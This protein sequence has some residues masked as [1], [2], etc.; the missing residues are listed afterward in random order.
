MWHAFCGIMSVLFGVYDVPSVGFC[1][2]F[3]HVKRRSGSSAAVIHFNGRNRKLFVL[4][5]V[6]VVALA[7]ILHELLCVLV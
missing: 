3:F 7:I 6:V 2:G 4:L 5:T 1:V